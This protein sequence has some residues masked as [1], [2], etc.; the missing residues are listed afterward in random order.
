MVSLLPIKPFTVEKASRVWKMDMASAQKALDELA[1]RAILVDMEHN[2]KSVYV[3]PP[4]M[5]GFFG[6]LADAGTRRY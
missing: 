1:G 2:G 6:I 3:L 5:A 4:P